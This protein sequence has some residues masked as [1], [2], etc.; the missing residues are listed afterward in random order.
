MM[1]MKGA[2]I[3]EK[4]FQSPQKIP[5]TLMRALRGCMAY[6]ITPVRHDEEGSMIFRYVHV[7]PV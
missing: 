3:A 2:W 1:T 5:W 4:G 6:D 7:F